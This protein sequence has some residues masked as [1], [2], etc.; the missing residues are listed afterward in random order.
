MLSITR[1]LRL[2]LRGQA[3]RSR[4]AI[5]RRMRSSCLLRARRWSMSRGYRTAGGTGWDHGMCMERYFGRVLA[6]ALMAAIVMVIPPGAGS[7]YPLPDTDQELCFG[8]LSVIEPPSPGGAF[9]GHD[10]RFGGLCDFCADNGDGTVSGFS[11]GLMWEQT[12]DETGRN[13]RE[14]LAC[15]EGLEPGGYDEWRLPDAHELRCLW[16]KS[17]EPSGRCICGVDRAGQPECKRLPSGCLLRGTG[18]PGQRAL[19]RLVLV[20]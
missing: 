20:R 11:T 4:V 6:A 9:C 1:S 10:A 17:L 18:I 3:A 2:R 5:S 16:K 19:E 8:T 7:G 14:A 13:C 15:A 12:D